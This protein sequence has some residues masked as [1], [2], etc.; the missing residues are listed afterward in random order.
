M[1]EGDV[2]LGSERRR[3]G[4]ES[5]RDH[6]CELHSCYKSRLFFENGSIQNADGGAGESSEES[7]FCDVCGRSSLDFGFLRALLIARFRFVRQS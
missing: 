4:K 6:G 7:R 5:G 1:T 3:S 2:R